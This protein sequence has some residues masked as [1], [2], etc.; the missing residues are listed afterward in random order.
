MAKRSRDGR[1]RIE[2]PCE[3]GHHWQAMECPS[4]SLDEA[5]KRQPVLSG[6]AG[7]THAT[8]ERGER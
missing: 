5:L 8:K 4:Y 7:S 1:L 3:F 2:P 6:F